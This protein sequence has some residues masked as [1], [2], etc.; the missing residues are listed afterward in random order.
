M[1][2]SMRFQVNVRENEDLL[3][4]L[5]FKEHRTVREQCELYIH[6]KLQEEIAKLQPDTQ[7]FEAEVA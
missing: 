4:R 7:T 5:A 2:Q 6:L 1:L 3:R